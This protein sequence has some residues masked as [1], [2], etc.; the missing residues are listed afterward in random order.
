MFVG[1]TNNPA[2]TGNLRELLG[3]TLGVTSS[4]ND[5]APRIVAV[6]ATN[7]VAHILVSGR[8][9]RAGIQ[10]HD[11]GFRGIFGTRKPRSSIS[12]SI[13]APSACV[14]RHP[15]FSTKKEATEI[16]YTDHKSGD[17]QGVGVFS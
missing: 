10:D 6:D 8:R 13:A 14:A 11:L 5:L 3:S 9:N 2:Y 16:H 7:R 15:K 17:F 1:I 12:R 4:D